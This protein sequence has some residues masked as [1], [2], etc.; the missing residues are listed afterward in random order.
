[1][2]ATAAALSTSA[3]DLTSLTVFPA[4]GPAVFDGPRGRA[5]PPQQ[6]S[7]PVGLVPPLLPDR[8]NEISIEA[9]NVT[10]PDYKVTPVSVPTC[11]AS[12]EKYLSASAHN[13]RAE[14]AG[15]LASSSVET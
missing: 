3:A 9:L 13:V 4:L 7:V 11:S 1:M 12:V 14:L 15:L 8:N 10:S 2:A 5:S 6:A